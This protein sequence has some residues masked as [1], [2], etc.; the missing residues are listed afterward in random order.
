MKWYSIARPIWTWHSDYF[1][2]YSW[3]ENTSAHCARARDQSTDP[4]DARALWIPR[5][6]VITNSDGEFASRRFAART[7]ALVNQARDSCHLERIR[8]SG[9]DQETSPPR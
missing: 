3:M 9:S 7:L 5:E 2:A 8:Q 4:A 1:A 6:N